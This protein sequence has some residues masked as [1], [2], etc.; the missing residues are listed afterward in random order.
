MAILNN[1][2]YGTVHHPINFQVDIWNPWRARV[3]T[4]STRPGLACHEKINIL[5]NAQNWPSIH[6]T[7]Y[8]LRLGWCACPIWWDWQHLAMSNPPCVS[9]LWANAREAHSLTS[10]FTYLDHIF[11]GLPCFLVTRICDRFHTGHGMLY[12]SIPSELM[13][14]K[15]WD[16]IL[17][18]QFLK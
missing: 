18:A 4:S 17:N 1:L 10:I 6:T 7:I 2:L 11:L 14:W 12:L 16:N 15:N 8:I 9:G 3:A 5:W 13:T